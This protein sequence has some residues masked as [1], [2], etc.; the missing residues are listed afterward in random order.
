M[1][2]ATIKKNDV[3]NGP[4]VRVSLF[5][6]GCRHYCK[7][8]FNSEAWDFNYGK[9]FTDDTIDEIIEASK[10]SYIEGLSILGGEPFEVENQEGLVRLCR[11]FRMHFPEKSIW[12]YTGFLYDAEL[13]TENSRAASDNTKKLLDLI[14]FLVDGR[15]VEEKKDL[16]LL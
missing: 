13:L 11:A 10:P 5:V 14:D 16:S 2:Y 1:N 3:A 6:S 8:C 12:C 15:F 9:E 7:N 4:G